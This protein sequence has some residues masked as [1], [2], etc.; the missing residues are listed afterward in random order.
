M[1]QSLRLARFEANTILRPSGLNDG[2]SSGA[3]S[4]WGVNSLLP[5]S[6]S[7][8]RRWPLP[9]WREMKIPPRLPLKGLMSYALAHAM[10][11]GASSSV[12]PWS[13][14]DGG[15]GADGGSAQS[16]SV[17]PEQ[18]ARS[19]T[20]WLSAASAGDP[21]SALARTMAETSK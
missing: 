6:N 21:A 19:S 11:F 14:G 17:V 7:V 10:S 12:G 8:R 9:S 2:W 13:G 3:L 1:S 20:S 5:F 18:P 15:G 4:P 16:G